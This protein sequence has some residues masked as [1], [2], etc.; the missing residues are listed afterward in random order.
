MEEIQRK[1]FIKIHLWW[2]MVESSKGKII[3]KKS[4]RKLYFSIFVAAVGK[5]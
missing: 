3:E 1:I 2:L 4:Q 5:K